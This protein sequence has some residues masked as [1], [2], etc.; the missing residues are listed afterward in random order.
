MR[1]KPVTYHHHCAKASFINIPILAVSK[2]FVNT[3]LV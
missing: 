2:K 3:D 1:N